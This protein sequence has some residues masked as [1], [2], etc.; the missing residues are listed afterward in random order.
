MRNDH[1]IKESEE[2]SKNA[3]SRRQDRVITLLDKPD[4][5]IHDQDKI[6]ERIE[7]FYIELY[8]NEQNI[9]IHT[10]PNE[11]L[12]ITSWDVEAALRDMKNGTATGNDRINIDTLKAGE[13]TRYRLEDS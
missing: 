12:E 10:D 3:E 6:I 11:V 8:D 1:G 4:R 2:T 9:I 7:E 13:D 5:E